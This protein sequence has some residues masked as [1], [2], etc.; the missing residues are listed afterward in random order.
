MK[1]SYKL[2]DV[3]IANSYDTKS[4]LV[5]NKIAQNKKIKVIGNP[6]LVS[7]YE[8]LKTHKVS[9]EWLIDNELKVVLAVG[10][11]H[12]LKNFSFLISAFKDVYHQNKNARL[13]IV[14]EGDEKQRL[15]VQIKKMGLSEVV[16]LV[17]FQSNIYPYYQ[18]ADIFALSSDW[19]GFGNVLVEAL[20]V[21]LPVVSTNCP[22]GPKMILQN[23]TYGQLI[24]LD[25]KH[26]YVDALLKALANPVKNLESIDYAKCFTVEHVAKDY[27]Q[28]MESNNK[29]GTS[30][31]ASRSKA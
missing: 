18:Q 9:D 12:P 21:G 11:L 23:G 30:I 7:D 15:L 4:D 2:A 16:K 25:D 5:H 19:E 20:S 26:A 24:P 1:L 31:D 10:R 27:F 8:Q 28:I 29:R 14:G 22:G 17:P 6:V 13:M 3:V